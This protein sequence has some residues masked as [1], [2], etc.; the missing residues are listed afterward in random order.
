M[1]QAQI[2]IRVALG[3]AAK[4]QGGHGH[5]LLVG[6]L[7]HQVQVPAAQPGIEQRAVD[8]RLGGVQE[9]GHVQLRTQRPELV[10]GRVVQRGAEV[11]A[12]V[13]GQQAQFPH[14]PLKLGASGVDILHGQCGQADET[15]GMG[16]HRGGQI[17]VMAAAEV[18]GQ[19]GLDE[20]EVGERVG[21]QGLHRDA[22]GVHGLQAHVQLDE[23]RPPVGHPVELVATHPEPGGAV[24][25]GADFGAARSGRAHRALQHDVGVNVDEPG[26]GGE[27]P[28][29]ALK[30]AGNPIGGLP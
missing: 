4:Y 18:D 15:V 23:Q 9:V 24:V 7:Q 29:P 28:L 5:G 3:D 27:L 2:Q 12:G 16:G 17:V 1:G 20:V 21:R 25:V 10:E 13:A 19:L 22:L 26:H 30:V 6:V 11:G 14:R 8:A